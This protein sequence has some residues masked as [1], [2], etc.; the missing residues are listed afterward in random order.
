MP[1]KNGDCRSL[2]VAIT[3]GVAKGMLCAK[4]ARADRLCE[5][6]GYGIRVWRSALTDQTGDPGAA[7][8]VV[9]GQ[10]CLGSNFYGMLT[11]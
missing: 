10:C 5:I 4:K 8:L 6:E 9:I 11:R 1:K 3:P 2:R 7:G